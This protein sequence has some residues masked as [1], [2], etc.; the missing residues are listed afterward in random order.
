MTDKDTILVADDNEN[1]VL[2]LKLACQRAS[3][4]NPLQVV[5]NGDEAIAYI[6]G[7]GQYSD[8][9]RF[10]FPVAMLLDLNMP[11]KSGFEV[12]AWLQRQPG[13]KRLSVFI[14]TASM[15]TADIERSYEQ[16]ANGYLV[17]PTDLAALVD[18]MRCLRTWLNC[19]QLPPPQS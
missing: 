4:L 1:D 15:R 2:L 12:L 9:L 7:A 18:L 17:K 13:L 11:R 10:P 16:G 19:N 14:F 5:R 3:L 8:R 6:Q